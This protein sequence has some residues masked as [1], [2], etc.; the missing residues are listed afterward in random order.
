MDEF[1]SNRQ[2]SRPTREALPS[3]K[4][5]QQKRV[6][7]VV[8]GEVIR[9]KKSIGRKVRDIFVGDGRSV[10]D[11]ILE[12]IIVPGFR[13]VAFDA[14]QTGLEGVFYRGDS[15]P[16]NRRRGAI[17]G[18]LGRVDYQRY[19]R[20]DRR[21]DRRPSRGRGDDRRP[22]TLNDLEDIIMMSRVEADEVLSQ[23]YDILE[24]FEAVTVADLLEIIGQSSNNYTYNRYGW[25]DLMGSG[26]VRT[27]GGYL[28]D[29][30]RPELLKD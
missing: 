29:L 23:M 7:R 5:E 21:D 26:V 15:R 12:D 16:N 22:R 18:G 24:K 17:S 27:R 4:Q 11:M 20:D 30:P 28:L 9:R 25:T 10:R 6:T 14:F 8:E 3:S 19:S 2:S 13:D 1:P